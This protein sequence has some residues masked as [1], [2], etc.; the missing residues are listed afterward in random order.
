MMYQ[1]DSMTCTIPPTPKRRRGSAIGGETASVGGQT[2][3]SQLALAIV[4]RETADG[5][6][7]LCPKWALRMDVGI[8]EEFRI[9]II[10][11][12]CS[13]YEIPVKFLPNSFYIPQCP[14]RGQGD[15]GPSRRNG[16]S[17]SSDVVG[18]LHSTGAET[19]QTEKYGRKTWS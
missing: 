1:I 19:G 4:A 9:P 14:L 2:T 11:N 13:L 18:C 5:V 8:S 16:L 7:N 6:G 12:T 10:R 15:V 17:D 3:L